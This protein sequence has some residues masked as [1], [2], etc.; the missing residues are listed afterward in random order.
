MNRALESLFGIEAVAKPIDPAVQ[1][2]QLLVLL[3]RRLFFLLLTLS[4][5]ILPALLMRLPSV[6][7]H[8][9]LLA[10]LAAML[11]VLAL[12]LLRHRLSPEF[13]GGGLLA[14]L[15]GVA[16]VKLLSQGL[17]SIATPSIMVGSA[18]CAIFFGLPWA[19]SYLAA[20]LLMLAGIGVAVCSG[21][22]EFTLPP[23][24]FLRAGWFWL[25]NGAGLALMGSVLVMVIV[26][27]K[28]KL[29]RTLEEID[30]QAR[31]ARTQQ[32]L[33][34]L[35]EQNMEDGLI[36]QDGN[37]RILYAN[38]RI[39]ELSG[40]TLEELSTLGIERL[41]APE[42]LERAMKIYAEQLA[43][44]SD[45]SATIPL[46]EFEYVRK[47]G[48]QF[49]GELH[50]RWLRDS[51]GKVI[52]SVSITRDVTERRRAQEERR[53]LEERLRQ[54]E[55]MEAIGQLAGGIAHDFNNHLGGI[56]GAA[57]CLRLDAPEG[58]QSQKLAELVVTAA[59]R[60]A[61]LTR[62]LLVFSRRQEPHKTPLQARWLVEET[63]ALLRPGLP[64]DV[65]VRIEAAE[66]D[67][68]IS[69]EVAHLESALLNLGINARDAVGKKGEI[70]FSIRQHR[71]EREEGC[72]G[73][74]TLPPGSYVGISVRDTGEG[75][76]EETQHKLFTP[77][78]TT[79]QPGKG[80][81]LGLAAVFGVV[82]SHGGGIRVE[83]RVGQGSCFD[84]FLPAHEPIAAAT[85]SAASA[86]PG[87]RGLRI[88]LV[89][90]DPVL[91]EA[92]SAMLS[93]L[94]H[95]VVVCAGPADALEAV[96]RNGSEAELVLMDVN[97][98]GLSGIEVAGEIH[99]HSP[100]V[101]VLL[102]SGRPLS[103]EDAARLPANVCGFLA[104]PYSL[105]DL[106][107]EI[108]RLAPSHDAAPASSPG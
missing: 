38:P 55:K 23:E 73:G 53:L 43:R 10:D 76:S 52:G 88:V 30:R 8:P 36:V 51:R 33:Y 44:S 20:G 28:Q 99:R 18:L 108:A 104:K 77:F 86:S 24:T 46:M 9:S 75:M 93:L 59:K 60:A 68:W 92:T 102:V 13:V 105:A 48:S 25:A 74:V 58:S 89:E 82:S 41:M 65:A 40:Y 2:R 106:E 45:P 78:F 22:F 49:F 87:R 85:T 83:S 35:I 21:A 17:S 63:V 71:L 6:G 19:I 57:D 72:A 84:V 81:G 103:L 50:I 80:T 69:G 37:L 47:D 7:W 98:P 14:A 56:M 39:L 94:N 11:V 61:D 70:V 54:A 5:V 79:K 100:S 1:T 26:A 95:Q 101:R 3:L 4:V 32:R 42:S 16:C 15:L 31:E 66:P 97:M 34:E 96:C 12:L 27:L 29:F 62:Q 64:P 90:D 107:K 67:L 91:R